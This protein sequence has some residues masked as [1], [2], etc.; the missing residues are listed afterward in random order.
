MYY[1]WVDGQIIDKL[2]LRLALQLF[3]AYTGAVPIYWTSYKVELRRA[4]DDS[5]VKSWESKGS[6]S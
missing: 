5:V 6:K 2:S 3:R 4:G 1:L